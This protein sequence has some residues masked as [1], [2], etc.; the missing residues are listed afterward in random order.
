MIRF[1]SFM[2]LLGFSISIIAQKIQYDKNYFDFL[3]DEIIS[4]TEDENAALEI[5][6]QIEEKLQNPVNLN[7]ASTEDLKELYVL[8]DFQV[9]SIL[10]FRNKYGTFLSLNELQ[11]I[12]GFHEE[13]IRL[14]IPMIC[15]DNEPKIINTESDFIPS[16]RQK[17]LLRTGINYPEKIG[18]SKE[19][20]SLNVFSGNQLSE[21]L[22]Y[23]I[24]RKGSFRSGFT[25][26]NDPGEKI[27]W[28]KNNHGTDFSSAYFE[29]NNNG[30]FRKIILGDYRLSAGSGLVHGY[31]RAGKSSIIHIKQNAH[32]IKKYSSGT[33]YGFMRGIAA[34][35]SIRNFRTILYVSS[36]RIDGSFESDDKKSIISTIFN[37]GLHR[38]LEEIQHRN[39]IRQ[40][41]WGG[42]LISESNHL[43]L[44]YN[45]SK[46]NFDKNLK[47]R[48]LPDRYSQT[49][50][51]NNFIEQSIFYA[52][53][54][55][56]VMA[57]GEIALD[58]NQHLA[59]IQNLTAQLHPLV[60]LQLS[61]RNYHPSYKSFGSSSLAESGGVSNEIGFYA[62]S[63]FY[64]SRFLRISFYADRYSFPWY[65]YSSNMPYK[66]K[67]YLIKT[68]FI[69][70]H[71]LDMF[72]M[73]KREFNFQNTSSENIKIKKME[74]EISQRLVFQSKF[75]ASEKL[76]FKTKIEIKT[77]QKNI[78]KYQGSFIAQEINFNL[79]QNRVI[80]N[81]RY[82][83]FDIPDWSVRIYS[84]ESDVFSSFSSPLFNH[85]GS[86]TNLV[87]KFNLGEKLNLWMKYAQTNYT[88]EIN[89][90]TGADLRTGNCFREWKLQMN[91]K[92]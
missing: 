54:Y 14:I 23:E 78:S 37:N 72:I 15:L 29:L 59:T 69:F 83:I 43:D 9:F 25:L 80:L 61:Y 48:I 32:G 58:K 36:L 88:S 77:D 8:S 19:Q 40:I 84:W 38:N 89:S 42:T 91:L 90:G 28:G 76:N 3:L 60:S 65:K 62:G 74:E 39:N 49:C 22:K 87:M 70:N 45:F 10:Q 34:D 79:F 6:Q 57:G 33:E 13:T 41:N 11:V 64:P 50:T 44:G 92:F 46:T 16:V 55:G 12:P 1:I 5:L 86:R 31:G 47:Y 68:D 27:S 63:V 51:D 85:R 7:T 18:F 4:E 53:R 21:L 17:L 26:E 20:D 82:A 73:V 52:A 81:T 67:D 71:D 35:M 24:E 56:N 30:P 2:L 75:S 66:G